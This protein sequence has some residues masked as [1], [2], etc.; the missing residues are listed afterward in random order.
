MKLHILAVLKQE[1]RR[2]DQCSNSSVGSSVSAK[3]YWRPTMQERV[4]SSSGIAGKHPNT[5][6]Q[7]S[8]L[9]VTVT[10]H[11]KLVL[12]RVVGH[13]PNRKQRP[14][15]SLSIATVML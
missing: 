15:L 7:I 1:L 9:S 10:M 13:L 4:L 2:R 11:K 6:L 8:K 5:T 3:G 12:R 14:M